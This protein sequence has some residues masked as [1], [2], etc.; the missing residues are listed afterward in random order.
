MRLTA[1]GPLLAAAACFLGFVALVACAYAIAPVERWDATA[2]HGLMELDSNS[3]GDP[4]AR[5]A[6][7]LP[8][9]LA[10]AALFA[11]GWALGRRRE[12]IG[13]LALVTVANVGGLVLQIALAH[14]RFHPILGSNQVGAEAYPSGHATSAMSIALAAVLVAPARLRVPVG[15]GAAAYVI[16]VSASLLVLGWHFPSD[17]LG[18]LLI[19]S[20]FF[21]LTVAAL[22]V[23]AGRAGAAAQR[24]GA[25]L[26]P[27]LGAAAALLAGAGL[28]AWSGV[29]DLLSFAVDNTVATVAAFAVA[30]VAAGLVASATLISDP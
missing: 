6:D 5:S 17:V 3:I 7:P 29:G 26:S 23:G 25:A 27:W 24:V 8:I 16:A 4:L 12:A 13:A 19:S 11:W 30:A 20:G 9:A 1:R 14:P 21:F 18:G 10:L 28:V 2:L 15:C 22:R